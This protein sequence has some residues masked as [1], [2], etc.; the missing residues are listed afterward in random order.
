MKQLHNITE[1]EDVV[2]GERIFVLDLF[3]TWCEPCQRM[4]PV[5]EE[6][7]QESEIPFFKVDV[8]EVPEAAPYTGAKVVPT[9]L[10][11]LNG[12]K[13]E[14]LFGENNKEAIERKIQKVV[15]LANR[16]P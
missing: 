6:M 8:D 3:G 15:R 11:Y 2:Q 12:R 9:I 7:S 4:L 5:L 14:F 1:L 10:I 13:R 16:H